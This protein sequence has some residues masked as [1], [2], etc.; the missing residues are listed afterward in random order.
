MTRKQTIGNRIT[1]V[2]LVIAILFTIIPLTAM[3]ATVA[4]VNSNRVA[5]PSTM[6][7]WKNLFHTI[8]ELSTEN[9]GSV[10]MDKSVFTDA[11]AFAD[12]GITQD[13]FNSFLVALSAMAANMSVTGM[14][15]V[16]TDTMLVLDVSGSMNRSNNDVAEDLVKAAN[17]SISA[18]LSANQY[19]RVGVVLYSGPTT[20]GGA[21]SA[22]DA[23]LILPLGRYT[24][25]SDGQY[26]TY[27]AGNNSETVSLSRNVVY[28]ETNKAPF[29][30]RPSKTVVG[31]TYI[32]KGI[33]LAMNQFTD[34]TN[35]VTVNDSVL[36]TLNRKPV[37]VL[38]SDGAPTV[39]ST[40]FTVPS[41]IQLGDGTATT[42]ALGFVNQLSAAYAKAKIEETY[43]SDA[44]FYTLGLGIG[45]DSIALAVLDPDHANASTAVDDF[46]NDLQRNWRGQIT[47]AGYNR[48]EVGEKVS[49]GGGLSVTKIQ[50]PLEQN[51]V[52]QYFA[53]S[54]TN[55]VQVFKSIMSEIQLQSAYFPTLVS[56]SEELSG[57]VSF[58]DKIGEY[59]SVTDIKGILM[60][61]RLFSGADLS[62]NFVPGG[63]ALGT[64]DNPT[65]LGIEMVAAVRAR[66][67]IADDDTARTLISLAYEN[68]QLSYTDTN[69]YSN[70]I[71]WYANADG[72]FLG[73][74]N[75]GTTIL[76]AATGNAETDP[77]YLIRSYGYLGAVDE[78]HG[79]RESDMM[80]ATVQVRKEIATGEELVT[81]AI[82]AA[83]IPT[84]TYNVTLDQE[85]ALSELTVEG[86]KNPIRLVYE[87]ALDS[88]INS[89]NVKEA[90]SADYL[91]DPHNLNADGTVNF[92]TN[93][94]E[95]ENKTG[96]GT[97]NTYSYFNPSRQNDQYYYLK[98]APVYTDES[99]TLYTGD[100][101]P[102][103]DGTFYRSYQIYK[104]NGSLS[105]ETVY[106][107]LSDAAKTTAL[108]K[109]DGSWYIPAGNVHVNLDGKTLHKTENLT[110][111][112]T[113]AY[114]PFV[115]TN[116][117][118]VND[119]GYQ[120]YVGATLG[121][122]G[123][124]TVTPETGIKLTK[125]MAEG[126]ADP[127]TA[128]SFTLTN[129]T[130]IADGSTHPAWL[131]RADGTE[132]NTTVTFENGSATVK[133]H[134]GDVLYVGGMTAGDTFRIAER[135]SVDYVASAEGL[136]ESGT[137]TVQKNEITPISF[138]NDERGTGNLT[139]AKE[140]QHGFGVDY[141][142]PADKIF[143][144]QV[145]LSGIGTANA[146]FRAEHTDG[147]YTEITTDEKGSFTVQLMHDQQ[148]E[149][150]GLPAG[151]TAVVVE[152]NPAEG[153]TPIYLDNGM[154]GDG[155]VTVVADTTV[156]VLVVNDYE[157]SEV[158]PVHITVSGNKQ[159][160]G[161][162][163][164]PEYSFAFKLEKLL[165]DGSWQQLGEIET[166]SCENTTFHFDDAFASERYTAPGSYYYRIVEIEPETPLGGFTYDKTVHSFSVHVGDENMDGHLEIT[167]VVSDRPDTTV[168]TETANGWNVNAGFTNTYSTSGSAT[169]TIDVTKSISNLGG[170]DKSLAGYTFGLFHPETGEQVAI[171]TTTERGFARFVLT[172][173]A[174]EIGNGDHTFRYILKEVAPSPIPNGWTYSTDE[175][176]VTVEVTDNGDGTISAVIF[177]GEEKPD[178]PGTSIAATFTNTY[179]PT[180][181]ELS[182]DFVNK[183]LSGRDLLDGEF[184]FEVQTEKGETV[185]EGVNNSAGKVIFD[186]KLKFDSVGT[187]FYNIVETS[188]DANGVTVDQTTYRII[189]TV[190]DVNG[191]L[192][193]S[194]VLT[195]ATGDTVTFK[196]TYTA[197]PVEHT[198]EGTKTLRGRILLNDEFTFV[199]TELSVNG[200][201]VE[202]PESL[203]AKNFSSGKILFPTIT[204][205]RAGTY[206]YSVREIAPDGGKAYG[207]TYDSTQYTVTVVV[208]DNGKGALYVESQ[209]VALQNGAEAD[210]IHFLNE[211]HANPTWAQFVGDKQ[212]T[213]KVNDALRGGEFEFELYN[214]D[215]NWERGTL[216]ETVEN[217][218]GGIITFTKID[219]DTD[220]DQ[221]FIV[222]EKNGGKVID[223]ITYDDTIY[224]IWVEV[225]DDLKGQ[226]YATVH[227]YDEEGIPQDKISFVNVYEITGGAG[228]DLSGEKIIDGREWKDSDRFTFELYR[229][230]ENYNAEAEPLQSV[231]VDSTNRQ[232]II[233]LNYTA[234]DVGKTY[235]YLLAEQNGG[236]TI[237]GLT[238]SS[239]AYRIMVVVEDD[240][241]GGIKTTVTVVDATTTTL[242]FVNSYS[243]KEATVTIEGTKDLVGRDPV[244]GEFKFLLTPADEQFN[245]LEGATAKIAYNADGAFTFETLSFSEAGI[246]YF[247]I[248]EDTTVE[249]ERVTF[250]ET[251][252]LV[253]IEITDDQN[254]KLI[255]SD[256]VIVKQ[257]STDPV[258]TIAFTNVFVPKPA[259]GIVDILVNKTVVNLG[260]AEIGPEDFEFLL[261]NLTA[262][263]DG[264][265]VKSD[266]EGK[267][268]FTLTYTEDDIGKTY[269][270]KLTEVDDGRENVTYSKAEYFITVTVSRDEETNTLAI[271]L[272][273]T[274]ATEF[275]AEFENV[276]DY[277]PVTPDIPLTGDTSNP[278]LWIALM[279][280]SGGAVLTLFAIERKKRSRASV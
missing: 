244:N 275:V 220:E 27:S 237:N 263:V 36:G 71:G 269:H 80:Y 182:I 117:H 30:T 195:N 81:F 16:P 253:T 241:K 257:G 219:F 143:T 274:S 200:V 75:E 33:A 169:V 264:I 96:Y 50:T 46:W 134:A 94:W 19:N 177:T 183:E 156:S 148:F 39:G 271:T 119:A 268:K 100:A 256:P 140:V 193:A 235:Y 176:V 261:E 14:S 37:L 102:S 223:G 167:E 250:D 158:Y 240:N 62:S 4:G 210:A 54:T 171:L 120:F 106:R 254:G 198:I 152:Q 23:V 99:G 5:D 252:Y 24:T 164:Q 258:E 214:S 146:T 45:N 38:M 12:F 231:T 79:V 157:A 61:D 98:D 51:Y 3:A 142:I 90:V 187:Y 42:A 151:T 112:L 174:S 162:D 160:S 28:E 104:N 205:T 77:A 63:G 213:G 145:T 72:A 35:S 272:N 232:Y 191:A 15:G 161:T 118:S 21:T 266:A 280:I 53:A 155:S 229:A 238:Y 225:N 221:Y 86:A 224:H 236:K 185:L 2:I 76:P 59:M 92:Y 188:K 31:G 107:E 217:A 113:E 226:L 13:S 131:I 114:I 215:S 179:N 26:L 34:E 127:G 10:W 9:A 123:K 175:V 207:I 73:F 56:K 194:Y 78:S 136:T 115:D 66:L 57:Y 109:A 197:T 178:N 242:N 132:T 135:E 128:F 202:P 270:Y 32:Q 29:A 64:Y 227:I 208:K 251:V 43:K 49:V 85:G 138:V 262:E 141:Q 95:H 133:L 124:L 48:V 255:A 222:V 181:A 144:M 149:V 218:A 126:V 82:P 196:N 8:G 172:Y 137:V 186:G 247:L 68:G 129:L 153:F 130:N 88:E 212:L 125:A 108:Q 273:E 65:A 6:D 279:I 180:D 11:S 206:V 58:V 105:T 147:T 87:V 260:T 209:T 233:T 267:A 101:Q 22:N 246:Y 166:A 216:K 248:S 25:G 228:V 239:A 154:T 184:T 189:V 52:D 116:Q 245:A 243:A 199:R 278:A 103:A 170:A 70:Y 276:Y 97:V 159:L 17:E 204:Y 20:V 67:G 74:Y 121:N 93:Q 249:A 84:V 89:F 234:A 83:L 111:T 1:S 277:T 165:P 203:T 122:N 44:L 7:S 150:F 168:I 60:G 91:S 55:L 259:D 190:T 18:L 173:H 110:A 163:W 40:N 211:Y 69:N 41:A 192:K 265:T 201:A 139:V 47:F 230:D